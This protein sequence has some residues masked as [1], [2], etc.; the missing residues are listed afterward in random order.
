MV[1]GWIKRRRRKRILAR[2]I[3]DDWDPMLTAAVP[4][5]RNWDE[6]QR[7]KLVDNTRIFIEEKAW[8]GCDGLRLTEEMQVVIAAQ[9]SMMLVGVEDYCFDAVRT[10]LVYP[11][12]FRRET[13]HGLIVSN[14]ARIGEAWHR[15]PIVLSW[16]DVARSLPGR[17]VVVHELAHHLDGLDG[18]ISGNPILANRSDQDR[19]ELV[20]NAGYEKL[21]ADLAAGIPTLLDCYA[22]TDRAEYFAVACEAFFEIPRELKNDHPELYHCLTQLFNSDPAN[23]IT[24]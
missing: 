15:G 1:F 23:W 7:R 19:W 13:Q 17:N 10:I 5:Y 24:T 22:A 16:A 14:E 20:A 6:G 8:E 21:L 11:A 4:W 18:D 12:S 9:A 3:N 2:P